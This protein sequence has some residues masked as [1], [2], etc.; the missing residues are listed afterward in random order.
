M[1]RLAAVTGA[2][3]FVGSHIVQALSNDG[4]RLRLLVRR[5]PDLDLGV[6]PVQRARDK[7]NDSEALRALV[8][9]ADAVIHVAGAIKARS[10][11][12]FMA[13]NAEGTRRVVAAR[14]EVAPGANLIMLSSLA[15]RE[16]QL[17]HYA[18]SKAA[19][20]A[21]L[22]NV[23]GRWS[24]LRP[25]AIYGPGDRETLTVFKMAR[26]PLHP[27]LNGPEARV[28][29]VNVADVVSAIA[30]V[31][32]GGVAPGTYEVSDMRYDGYAWREIVE[33]ACASRGCR[34][35]PVRVP[36]AVV[37]T[38][39]RLGDI[40]AHVS[41]SAEMLTSQKVREILHQDWSSDPEAQLPPHL[42][43]PS[44]GVYDGFREAVAWYRNSGWLR[45]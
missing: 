33:A 39:G 32:R 35:R 23:G 10:R 44:V 17:S 42:W 21:H 22:R 6:Q 19:G 29:L 5:Q 38:L 27:L 40:G 36:S 37:R 43:T 25:S 9:G 24:V 18:A 28:C 15:A 12:D 45:D 7:L 20:E 31:L 4:W 41:G 26:M 13:V 2:T 8:R 16:P 34:A 30:T 1:A 3:G 11:E 14:E